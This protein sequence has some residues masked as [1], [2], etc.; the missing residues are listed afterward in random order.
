[1]PDRD[2]RQPCVFGLAKELTRPLTQFFDRG[3]TGGVMAG[4]HGGQQA[5]IFLRIPTGKA[6]DGALAA[7]HAPCLAILV[8]EPREGLPRIPT[9]LFQIAADKPFV[10]LRESQVL[11]P[12]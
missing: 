2:G 9:H 7:D 1:M 6:L 5:N 3:P 12:E 4:I 11:K 8:N 10:G